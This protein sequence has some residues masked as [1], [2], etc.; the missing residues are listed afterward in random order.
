M[1]SRATF[2]RNNL[3]LPL[4]LAAIV[5]MAFDLTELDR[6]ISNLLLDPTTGQFPLLHNQWF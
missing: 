1:P 2:Y 3:L 5:F 4:L 6:W